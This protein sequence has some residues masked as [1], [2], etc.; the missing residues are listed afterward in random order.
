M[1]RRDLLLSALPLASC[2]GGAGST[3]SSSTSPTMPS[4]P[5]TPTP[6]GTPQSWRPSYHYSPARN[7]M[8]DPN[9]LVH[10]DG[11]YHLFYQYNPQ[12]AQWGNI[13]WGHAVSTDLVTWQEKAEALPAL[14][15]SMAFS[16]SI[17]VDTA[18][19]AGF[20]ASALVAA[21]TGY[22]PVTQ[23]QSQCLASS[24]DHGASFARY[25]GNPVL[26]IGSQQF[27]DPRILWHAPTG[28]WVMLVVAAWLQEVWFYTSADL[29]DWTK[30]S[31]FGPAGSALNNIWEVPDLF[32]LSIDGD[33]A[34]T[35][36][37]LI[38]SVNHGSLWGGSGVQYFIGDF[39]GE[40]FRADPSGTLDGLAPPPGT[41]VADFEGDRYPAGWTTTGTAFGTGPAAGTLPG[42]NFVSGFLGRGLVNT[43]RGGDTGTGTLTSPAFTIGGAWLSFLLAGGSGDATRIELRVD[44]RIVHQ[45][46]GDDTE[47]LKWISWDVS[48]LAG[49]QAVLRIV[50]E[51]TD[52]WGHVDLDHVVMGDTPVQ[53]PDIAR[54]ALWADH[55]RDFY[56]PISF[57]NMPDGRVVWLGWMS[58]W[59]YAGAIPTDPWRGQQSLPRELDLA[60]TPAGPRLRQRVVAE[61]LAL[62]DGAALFSAQQRPATGMAASLAAA[63]VT[64]R[65]LMARLAVATA[66]LRAPVGLAL[67]AGAATS[68][69]VGYDP[70]RDSYFVD[71][72]TAT[73][74]FAGE[75][76]RHDAARVLADDTVDMEVWIDGC[77]VE[78]FADGG[79]VAI[80]DLVFPDAGA[81]GVAL[82]HG[83]ENPTVASLA[84]HAVRAT[85]S[86]PDD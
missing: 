28:R 2:G 24:T 35:R 26:D 21:F 20:G 70:A 44:G 6:V 52:G 68:V 83:D 49:R 10:V 60:T 84:L 23:I 46:S 80:S 51:S 30:V 74:R 67:F 86:F 64:G 79:L 18:N 3:P 11:T 32:E 34:D 9:G 38:V 40:R 62:A 54:V 65:R 17:V 1:R 57:A 42:Q 73:P 55:G 31:S 19:T 39:D 48:A 71:R 41:L 77:T 76:E 66:G 36:W 81:T 29:R 33:P 59:D 14:P 15:S 69:R 75:S 5:D 37:V 25:P 12:G 63:A 22:D 61:A 82:F 4:N 53:A 47:V 13:G 43:F 16:G 50:D 7:W 56:A 58:N 8:N 72:S 78:L 85:M 27:R 45:A